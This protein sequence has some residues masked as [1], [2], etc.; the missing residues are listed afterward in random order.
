MA[1]TLARMMP[2][3]RSLMLNCAKELGKRRMCARCALCAF[4]VPRAH[5]KVNFK[6][7]CLER[8]LDH[9]V[10]FPAD[11]PIQ[12]QLTERTG[13]IAYYA[14]ET[15]RVE[16]RGSERLIVRTR[17]GYRVRTRRGYR[18]DARRLNAVTSSA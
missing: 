13:G 8:E 16:A 10:S 5:T 6:T 9:E 2:P 14:A 1:F 18:S 4:D 3:V 12:V 15:I 17:R 11:T 7:L